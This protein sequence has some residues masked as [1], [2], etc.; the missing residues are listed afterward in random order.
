MLE[1]I[2]S[3]SYPAWMEATAPYLPDIDL[4]CIASSGVNFFNESI[5][6]STSA[7]V[8]GFL[9][10]IMVGCSSDALLLSGG[11]NNDKQELKINM[12]IETS[13]NTSL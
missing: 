11:Y 9:D 7:T 2:A 3:L 10:A 12:I 8:T 4:T 5:A 6:N 13:A 1:E